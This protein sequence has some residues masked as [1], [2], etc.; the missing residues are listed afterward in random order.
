M[1]GY[2]LPPR[3][4]WDFL[5]VYPSLLI[6]AAAY[7]RAPAIG[8]GIIAITTMLKNWADKMIEFDRDGDGLME[9]P[10]SGNSGSWPVELTVRP[11][12]WWERSASGTRTPIPTRS[13][14]RPSGHGALAKLAGREGDGAF[15][16]RAQK[17]KASLLRRLLQ[18]RNRSAGRLASADGKLHDY[19]FSFVNGMAV[20]Y[21][22]VTHEQGN[23]IW[24]RLWAKMAEVGYAA[25]TW[26]ARQPDSHPPRRLRRPEPA[27]WRPSQR[28]RIRWLSSIS[29]MAAL[30]PALP[31][32]PFRLYACSVATCEA[33]MI[34]YPILKAFERAASRDGAERHKL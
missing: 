12:N 33:D 7:V 17:L 11:A 4:K 16:R 29:R 3:M 22:L 31:T 24:D 28:R 8:S 15:I 32:S 20:T 6:A 14:I 19:Y 21:G 5:D 27:L 9:Y 34:C 25:S 26:I 30:Q 13:P 18:S 2:L 1:T 23:R 10:L